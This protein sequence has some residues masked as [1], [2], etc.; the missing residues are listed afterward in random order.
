MPLQVGK[1]YKPF[2]YQADFWNSWKNFRK[3]VPF[4]PVSK[5]NM[6][7]S[8]H[9]FQMLHLFQ[10]M[11]F[12]KSGFVLSHQINMWWSKF[13]KNTIINPFTTYRCILTPLRKATFENTVAKTNCSQRAIL[14]FATMFSTLFNYSQR[15]TIFLPSCFQSRLL[16]ICCMLK[17]VKTFFKS[18]ILAAYIFENS[19]AKYG[20]SL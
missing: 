10:Q 1:G 9:I 18:Q 14:P 5:L 8:I 4:P 2:T 11:F 3:I 15:L 19:Y 6:R 17:R 20:K 12:V 16:Y 7:S 13:A